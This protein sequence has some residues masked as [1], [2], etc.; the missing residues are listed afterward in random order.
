MT[1]FKA[2]Q[3]QEER[4]NIKRATV[5]DAAEILALQKLAFLSEAELCGDFTIPPLT[6]TLDELKDEFA[7]QLFLKVVDDGVI[8]GSVRGLRSA[9]SCF[10]GRLIVHPE[11][12]GKGIGT[13]MMAAIEGAFSGVERFEL[14]TGSKSIANIRLYERLGY[15][16]FRKKIVSATLSLVFMEKWHIIPISNQG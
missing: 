2:E 5:V 16:I 7:V 15:R 13:R 8:T 3:S 10:I 11:H 4:V 12:Q 9:G 1:G 14:F 6:Q